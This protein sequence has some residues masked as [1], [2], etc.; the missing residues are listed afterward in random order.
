[1]PVREMVRGKLYVEFQSMT[2]QKRFSLD[3]SKLIEFE[4]APT[5]QAA[6]RKQNAL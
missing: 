2:S 5:V 6:R 4:E 3:Q 1:M